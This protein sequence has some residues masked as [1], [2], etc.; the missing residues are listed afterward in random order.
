MN[1]FW[2]TLDQLIAQST[3]VIDRPRHSRHPRYPELIYPYD[4]GYLDS[5]TSMDGGGIDLWRGTQGENT[6]SAVIVTVDLIKRDSE[7]KLLLGCTPQEA[8][9]ILAFHN[10]GFQAA[11]LLPR[12][13]DPVTG[14]FEINP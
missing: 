8:E 5:T 12:P 6:L 4:Y 9:E 1:S 2:P 3:V 11:I 14:L 13:D 7:I 10:D